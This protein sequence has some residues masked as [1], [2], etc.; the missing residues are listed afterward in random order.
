V[1]TVALFGPSNPLQ[2]RPLG[3][4]VQVIHSPAIEGIDVDRVDAEVKAAMK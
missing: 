4:S 3:P 2:W 1:P